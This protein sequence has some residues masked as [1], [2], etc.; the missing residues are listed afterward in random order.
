MEYKATN[1]MGTK[2]IFPLLM[3]MA[4]PP[5]IS[6]MVQSLYN[7]IDSMF[8]ASYSEAALTAVSLA[9]PIQNLILSVAV[10]TGT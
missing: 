8:V 5:M 4:F 3:S 10:G 9:F 2:S 6:M 1:K 7:I